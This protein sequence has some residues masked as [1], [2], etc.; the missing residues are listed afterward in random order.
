VFDA[1]AMMRNFSGH[2]SIAV[3]MLESLVTDV[4]ERIAA[5]SSSLNG[6]DLASAEREAHTLKGLGGNGGA[7]LLRDLAE[8][9]ESRCRDGRL[10]EARRKLPDLG[11]EADRVLA[12]WSAF[13]A[14]AS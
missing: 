6:G 1:D 14:D 10:E 4:P 11:S 7:P 8:E 5:L 13:L 2:R 12:E 3:A 9:I